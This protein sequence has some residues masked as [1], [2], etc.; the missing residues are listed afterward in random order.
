VKRCYISGPM[1]G[2]AAQAVE[3]RF[4]AAS[5]A[6]HARGFDAWCPS[7]GD[8]STQEKLADLARHD[9]EVIF[10]LQPE[11]GDAV[12][13]LPGHELSL[14]ARAEVALAV[15]IGIRVLTLA[16]ALEEPV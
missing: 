2:R 16:E 15:W 6:L 3:S 5:R 1:R 7:V 13:V 12:V 9:V 4:H 11:R 10:S 14:G 8:D